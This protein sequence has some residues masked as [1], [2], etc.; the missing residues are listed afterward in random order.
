[1]AQAVVEEVGVQQHGRQP[2]REAAA[3]V[4]VPQHRDDEGDAEGRLLVR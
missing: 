3:L 4:P 2:P 1:M